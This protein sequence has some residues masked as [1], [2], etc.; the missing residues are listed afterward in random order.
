M[1]HS[2]KLKRVPATRAPR[3]RFVIYCEGQNTEPRYFQ[4][5]RAA[6]GN[7]SLIETPSVPS[8]AA[9]LVREAIRR[10]KVEHLGKGRRKPSNSF[11]QSDQVWAV[12]DHDDRRNFDDAIHRCKIHG[13]R[14]GWSNP[15]FELWLILHITEFE[16]PDASK[17]V[18]RHLSTLNPT[19]DPD[20]RKVCK[21]AE[22]GEL[23]I[24]AEK[25]AEMQLAR[26]EKEGDPSGRPSTTVGQLTKEIREASDRA[27]RRGE[28]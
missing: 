18:C 12:F 2:R 14:V 23:V 16:K 3:T 19:Y 22:L 13:V 11:E 27:K 15:C 21:W 7:L 24:A 4:D 6:Y 20:R 28:G 5:V 1:G 9:K 10:T 17:A 8:D 26:R 25:R